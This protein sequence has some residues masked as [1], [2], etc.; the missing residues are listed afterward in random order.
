MSFYLPSVCA[1]YVRQ[2]GW[3]RG[4]V[5]GVHVRQVQGILCL[6]ANPPPGEPMYGASL[7][8]LI[9]P[10]PAR[11]FVYGVTSGA[12]ILTSCHFLP[13][14]TS[15]FQSSQRDVVTPRSPAMELWL[16]NN[17]PQ[18]HDIIYCVRTQSQPDVKTETIQGEETGAFGILWP[19]CQQ[20][21]NVC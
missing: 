12:Q 21:R 20:E 14:E 5:P 15:L 8:T 16:P 17:S 10:A 11:S 7:P 6:I 18:S 13:L 19:R 9:S 2:S 4:C 1:P 3:R